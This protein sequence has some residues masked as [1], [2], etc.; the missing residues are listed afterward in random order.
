MH[1]M[2]FFCVCAKA[3]THL[4]IPLKDC[5]KFK[6]LQGRGW[7]GFDFVGLKESLVEC[8]RLDPGPQYNVK[9]SRKAREK[10]NLPVSVA[11]ST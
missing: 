8:S 6:A 3:G 7:E 5:P 9:L 2:F 11:K 4:K 1:V 10:M